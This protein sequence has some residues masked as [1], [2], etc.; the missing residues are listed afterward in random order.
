MDGCPAEKQCP[1]FA[2]DVY[3]HK[4]K[5]DSGA[6]V[7]SDRSENGLL[8]ALRKGQYGRCVYRCDNNQP[9]HVTMN[10]GFKDKVTATFSMEGMTSYG[11]RKTRVMGT[12][13]DVVGDDS[14]L[15]IANFESGQTREWDVRQANADLTGHGGGD[16]RMV[17]EFAAAVA[18]RDPKLLATNLNDSMESHLAGFLAEESRL[19]NGALREIKM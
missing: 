13:G 17:K 19:A 18:K 3:V 12:K 16:V 10:F 8:E 6:I 14:V 4:K 1:Y 15:R 7:T 5:W 9:D 11:G 2:P